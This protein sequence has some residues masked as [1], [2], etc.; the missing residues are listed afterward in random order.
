MYWERL[1]VTKRRGGQGAIC[2]PTARTVTT[3]TPTRG[4]QPNKY[5]K[6]FLQVWLIPESYIGTD[7]GQFEDLRPYAI[8]GQ[9]APYLPLSFKNEPLVPT[10]LLYEVLQKEILAK[11]C[12]TK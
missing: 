3:S 1:T 5:G 6:R 8:T 9:L 2:P 4:L 10:G 11:G 7:P 12:V